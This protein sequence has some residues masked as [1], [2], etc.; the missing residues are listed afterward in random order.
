[1][2]NGAIKESSMAILSA[3][4]ASASLRKKLLSLFILTA[5]LVNGFALSAGAAGEAGKYSIM[6]VAAAVTQN[7]IMQ[8]VN[9]WNESLIEVSKGIS[10][11]FGSLF[12]MDGGN[13]SGTKK[14]QKKEESGNGTAASGKAVIKELRKDGDENKAITLGAAISVKK[15]F[16]LY[17]ERKIPESPG[18]GAI[19]LLFIMFIIV[20][21][22][23]KGGEI[24]A[25][26]AL[27]NKIDKMKIP[28]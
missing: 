28:A 6:L 10:G 24:A 25:I 4:K 7:A 5:M 14:E 26:M 11:Y 13:F 9:K 1:M 17:G 3:R 22:Q 18:G 15:L 20:I 12:K 27:N 19:A 16:N 2:T 8:V 21:R 23:R